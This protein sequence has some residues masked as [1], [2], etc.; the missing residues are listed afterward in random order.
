[1]ELE[2]QMTMFAVLASEQSYERAARQL[3]ISKATVWRRIRAL[4]RS[5]GAPLLE[6]GSYRARLTP[7]GERLLADKDD[8]LNHWSELRRQVAGPQAKMIE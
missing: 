5:V 7:A 4:E 2:Q 8:L 6:R 3:N 1:V